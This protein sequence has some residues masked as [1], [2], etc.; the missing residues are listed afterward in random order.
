MRAKECAV[1]IVEG[2]AVISFV[3]RPVDSNQRADEEHLHRY[4]LRSIQVMDKRVM[5]ELREYCNRH[6]KE[7]TAGVRVEISSLGKKLSFDV[8]GCRDEFFNLR[9]GTIRK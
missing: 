6:I 8:K 4:D 2:S 5:K 7:I 1:E 9:W 3:L